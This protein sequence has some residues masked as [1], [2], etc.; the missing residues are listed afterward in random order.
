MRANG[1][2]QLQVC[3]TPKITSVISSAERATPS[4]KQHRACKTAEAW[5]PP[6]HSSKVIKQTSVHRSSSLELSDIEADIVREE[7]HHPRVR[8]GILQ[9]CSRGEP[10]TAGESANSCA[11][12][13]FSFLLHAYIHLQLATSSGPVRAVGTT[14]H[15][16]EPQTYPR[17]N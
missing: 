1:I 2:R 9:Q 17:C 16:S 6:T 14:L 11:A 15:A 12:A 8:K 7:A 10:S 5:S 3:L 13:Q 4:S